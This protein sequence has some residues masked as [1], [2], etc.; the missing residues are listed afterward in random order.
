MLA[1]A[2]GRKEAGNGA[3]SVTNSKMAE[4]G[5]TRRD[6]NVEIADRIENELSNLWQVESCRE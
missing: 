1:Q 6:T 3:R 2:T 5:R 4:S